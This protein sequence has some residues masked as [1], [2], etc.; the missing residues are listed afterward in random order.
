MM[1]KVQQNMKTSPMLYAPY[2]RFSC[3]SGHQMTIQTS[4]RGGELEEQ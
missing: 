4:G 1:Y 2:A 3:A